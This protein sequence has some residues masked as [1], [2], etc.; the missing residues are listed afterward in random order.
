MS[1]SVNLANGGFYCHGCAVKGG[2]MV[3]FLRLRYGLSFKD[4][5]KQLGAWDEDGKTSSKPRL[6]PLARY[7]VMDFVIDGIEHHAAIEDEPRNELQRLRRFHAE[8]KDRLHEIHDG[9]GEQFDG[10]EEVQSGILA[11]SSELIRMEMA[12]AR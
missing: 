3:V 4:A 8:A 12:D 5:C 10:E 2:D 6:G 9:C 11:T 1:F 7:L